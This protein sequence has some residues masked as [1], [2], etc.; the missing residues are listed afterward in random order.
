MD[1]LREFQVLATHLNY[2]TAASKLCISQSSLSRHI[3]ELETYIGASLFSKNPVRLTAAGD[4]FLERVSGIIEDFDTL[5]DETKNLSH[6]EKNSISVAL[7]A[8]GGVSSSLVY[9][10]F[11][12]MNETYPCFDYE[13]YDDRNY[14]I[15]EAVENGATDVGILRYK[16]ESY[17]DDLIIEWLYEE[18]CVAWVHEDSE[19]PDKIDG[20]KE[21]LPYS[22]VG[23][24]NRMFSNWTEC[25]LGGFKDLGLKPKLRIKNINAFEEFAIALR[26]DEFLLMA[27]KFYDFH[28]YNK[29][30]R[31]IEFTDQN[32]TMVPL[33]LVYKKE[34]ENPALETFINFCREK[35]KQDFDS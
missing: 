9:D 33:Y 3:V 4:H 17:P 30:L 25:I 19:L 13:I 22:L 15:I 2:T 5:V 24:N 8:W 31:K 21:L 1:R 7:L 23:S 29:L 18:P 35:A 34:S 28:R 16:P 26:K 6:L 12:S 27:D 14:T 20:L 10:A 11:A 32:S